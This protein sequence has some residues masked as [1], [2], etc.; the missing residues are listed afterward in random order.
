MQFETNYIN[1]D[2]HEVL[3]SNI[4]ASG[5]IKTYVMDTTHITSY[6]YSCNVFEIYAEK[7]V[8]NRLDTFILL[9]VS[10]GEYCILSK[11]F[12]H[13]FGADGGQNG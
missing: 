2:I 4:L 11:G 5:C 6:P 10:K 3:L 12:V 9:L 8:I 13:T 1:I 7:A